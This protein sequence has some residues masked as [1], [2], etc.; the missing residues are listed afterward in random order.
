MSRVLIGPLNATGGAPGTPPVTRFQDN[1]V[2][3]IFGP[4]AQDRARYVY[5][6]VPGVGAALANL[7][8]FGADNTGSNFNALH[9]GTGAVNGWIAMLYPLV[10]IGNLLVDGVSQYA[11]LTW[12]QFSNQT[13]SGMCTFSRW[14]YG[15]Q[16]AYQTLFFNN[17]GVQLFRLIAWD[18][19]TP[20]VLHS[21]APGFVNGDVVRTE[22][23]KNVGNNTITLKKNGVNIVAPIVDA[24]ATRPTIGIPGL[25]VGPDFVPFA[26]VAQW[27][28]LDCGKL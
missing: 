8:Y 1:F 21:S 13:S 5:A 4:S 6:T 2:N 9:A 20:R 11:Q 14:D 12:R 28:D 17:G 26:G 25:T 3:S 23:V 15:F 22:V 27:D 10:F 18:G 19:V 16:R 24:D 7:S